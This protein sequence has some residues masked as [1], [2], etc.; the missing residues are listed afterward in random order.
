[1]RFGFLSTYPPTRCGLATFTRSLA[2]AVAGRHPDRATVVRVLDEAEAPEP[3]PESNVRIAATL[4]AGDAASLQN[5]A[6]ALNRCDVV[7]VQHEYGIYGGPDGAEVLDVLEA[8]RVP[9]IAVLHTVLPQPSPGQRRV[10]ERVVELATATVVMTERARETLQASFRADRD[11]VLVIPHGATVAPRHSLSHRSPSPT[12]LTWGLIAPGKGI[13]RGIAAF[14]ALRDRGVDARYV[15]AGQTHPKVLAHAGE[16]Y[17]ESLVALAHE[18]GVAAS[19]Q[20]VNRYLTPE[21]LAGLLSAADAVL[22]PYDSHEQATSGVLVEALAEGAPVVA[23]AFPH[24]VE[25]LTGTAGI[26]VPHDDVHAMTLALE[27]VLQRSEARR[28]SRRS[29]S[30]LSWPEVADRYL[31]LAERLRAERAA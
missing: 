28:A 15:I 3:A 14:A 17:R 25:T 2:H 5:T 6:R 7:V 1:M 21:D 16:A 8:L 13:E 29:G 30:G 18:L 22:L 20:F 12:I 24:A 23:T 11:K 10:L 26:A 4:R 31:E 27:R 19:V 9:V